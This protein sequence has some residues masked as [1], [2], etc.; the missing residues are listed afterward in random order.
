M[1]K[2]PCHQKVK[3]IETKS[4]Q[5]MKYI[6]TNDRKLLLSLFF[7]FY[8]PTL[9]TLNHNI[10]YTKYSIYITIHYG[11]ENYSLKKKKNK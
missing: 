2:I 7:L 3:D 8:L 9:H 11:A 5:V 6:I 1:M 10:Q 4:K